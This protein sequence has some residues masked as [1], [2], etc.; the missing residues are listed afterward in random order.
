MS[1][2]FA[3]DNSPRTKCRNFYFVAISN[4]KNLYMKRA[5]VDSL[6]IWCYIAPGN[7]D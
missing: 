5:K 6:L 1:C 7:T 2:I 4:V 3:N